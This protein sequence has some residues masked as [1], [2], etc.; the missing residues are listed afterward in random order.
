LELT[1]IVV[2]DVL[3]R[4]SATLWLCRDDRKTHQGS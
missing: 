3:L 4:T 1:V 2:I